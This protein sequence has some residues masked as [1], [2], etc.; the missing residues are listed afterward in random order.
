[1]SRRKRVRVNSGP[2]ERTRVDL[3]M[4]T[5]ASDGHRTAAELVAV[6]AAARL[7]V[8]SITDH[9]LA[10]VVAAG[11]HEVGGV[12]LRVIAGVE[13]STMHEGV[14]LH[15][16]VYF[17]EQMPPDFARWCTSRAQWRARWFDASMSALGLEARA[18]ETAR[19][20]LRSLTRVH[21][22]RAVVEAGLAPSM[23]MAFKSWVGTQPGRIP[24]IDLQFEDA[25][26]IARDAGGWTS[27]AHPHTRRAEAWAPG[28]AKKGLHALEAWRPVGGRHR[29]ELLHRLA[30]RHGMG[31]TGGSDHHGGGGRPLGSFAVPLKA[32][33]ATA[34]ALNL[35]SG[36]VA[37]AP[38]LS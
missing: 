37:G 36:R 25:I 27:W 30:H 13:V 16:L 38:L 6:A 34:V 3:H 32:L 19:A 20:G 10:P 5:I 18:D 15:L 9:D 17:P 22:A 28:F 29:R 24:H 1:V 31:V 21:M 26:T 12:S 14:E 8:I 33:G 2:K 23:G 11:V 35:Q 7:D 4:H